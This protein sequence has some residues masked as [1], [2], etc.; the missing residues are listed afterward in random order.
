MC[1][2][3][4]LCHKRTPRPCCANPLE[5]FAQGFAP[6]PLAPLLL[7]SLDMADQQQA[8]TRRVADQVAELA[9]EA[10]QETAQR[11]KVSAERAV[12]TAAVDAWFSRKRAVLISLIVTVPIFAILVVTN[13][14]G[15]S[16]VDLMTPDPP[17]QVAQQDAKRALDSVVKRVESFRTDYST[18]PGG[19]IE[20]GTPPDGEWTYTKQ[21]GG[22]YQIA[23]KMFG[24]ALSFD[25][26]Q[27]KALEA[28]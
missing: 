7:S 17:P 1:G 20:V 3:G 14:T 27:R 18:L 16:L 8:G 9:Q 11:K 4:D 2:M 21:P 15:L 19:L 22:T 10:K 28:Q 12:H 24:Q 6:R 23:V 26:R 25:S 5:L 13:L